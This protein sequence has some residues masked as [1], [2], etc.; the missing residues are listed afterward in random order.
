MTETVFEDIFSEEVWRSTYKDS[1]DEDIDSTMM[2]VAKGV[3]NA[4]FGEEEQKK[5]TQKFYDMLSG[6]KVTAGGRIYS[7]A[8]TEWG[9]IIASS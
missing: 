3:A 9:G 8:G 2:R 1:K 6:F 7:N 4:E 5:W